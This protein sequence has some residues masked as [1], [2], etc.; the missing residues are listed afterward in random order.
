MQPPT[1]LE[2]MMKIAV[3]V[4]GLARPDHGLPPARLAGHRV[5]AGRILVAG[6]RVA[7]QNGVAFVGV[8]RAKS[9]I[10]DRERRN[11]AAAVG[12][13]RL[14]DRKDS[15]PAVRSISPGVGL[16]W[17][18][19]DVALPLGFRQSF[20]HVRYAER[21]VR[22]HLGVG[23][24]C[25]GPT[26]RGAGP[27][28]GPPSLRAS[29][30]NRGAAMSLKDRFVA[31]LLPMTRGRPRPS[32]R[33]PCALLRMRL[34]KALMVRS[35]RRRRLEPGGAPPCLSSRK[36][37][38]QRL[39]SRRRAHQ[40][41]GGGELG[42]VLLARKTMVAVCD[43]GQ[44]HGVGG[45]MFDDR[46]RMAPGHVRIAHAL[47]NMDARMGADHAAEQQMLASLLDQAAR[48]RRRSGAY[49]RAPQRPSP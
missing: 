29:Q 35:R 12:D 32:R 20:P 42:E 15:R 16:R 21:I 45:E 2:Q 38:A 19:R 24:T 3:G 5:D 26:C 33:A 48:D 40:V 7:E 13:E 47:Q 23:L 10:A 4:E 44:R 8:E 49:R 46:Q 28:L 22:Q 1:T 39:A 41:D 18:K 27:G 25:Q 34:P 36:Q 6:Q 30:S 9:L 43:E 11:A 17:L 37:I 31:S 14:L